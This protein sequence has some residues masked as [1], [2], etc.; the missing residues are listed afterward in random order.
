MKRFLSVI[1]VL[2]ITAGLLLSATAVITPR[3]YDVTL[4]HI[5]NSKNE[6]LA[7][8][9]LV[10]TGSYMTVSKGDP[11][12]ADTYAKT[13]MRYYLPA[14][15][16]VSGAI[17]M[18]NTFSAGMIAGNTYNITFIAPGDTDGNG[19]ITGND[20]ILAMKLFL[21]DPAVLEM[22]EAY[23]SAADADQNGKISGNDYIVIMKHFLEMIDL[24][25]G[26]D[27]DKTNIF[28]NGVE[29]W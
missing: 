14:V 9:G 27:F 28:E 22:D 1:L 17:G 12:K 19:I 23:K 29:A 18:I 26:F 21:T 25:V 3:G 6:E 15:T 11:G 10:G 7:A 24:N 2:V 13:D 16:A 4:S 8:D 20:Y 5:Y